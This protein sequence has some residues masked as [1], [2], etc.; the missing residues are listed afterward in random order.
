MG[1]IIVAQFVS[2]DG[3]TEDP[4]GSGGTPYGG[5]AFRN[6]A[7]VAGDKF[8]LGPVLDTGVM[9]L[10]RT[11]WQ[12]FA[13]LFARAHRR[14]LAEADGDGEARR[15]PLARPGRRLGALHPPGR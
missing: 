3:V 10:G 12:L 9:L 14:L 13:G 7:A 5:W 15:L 8:R 1:K 6:P 4:D 11:T 2:L